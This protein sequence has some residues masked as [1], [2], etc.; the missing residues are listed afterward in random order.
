MKTLLS[1]AGLALALVSNVQAAPWQFDTTPTAYISIPLGAKTHSQAVPSYGLALGQPQQAMPMAGAAP[2]VSA[3]RPPM[4]D[5]RF[6]DRTLHSLSLNGVNTLARR[7]VY[8][9]DG[10]AEMEIN[11][12]YVGAAVLI[13]GVAVFLAVDA[14]ND[15]DDDN[16]DSPFSGSG[17]GSGSSLALGSAIGTAL[18]AAIANRVR[19]AIL[20][21]L[22]NP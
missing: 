10:S 14:A 4:L 7:T 21:R 12:E 19:Q 1:A 11:W 15:S 17:S 8:G 6:R 22:T 16:N 3:S 9:A 18:S 20:G 13:G 2:L 5:L